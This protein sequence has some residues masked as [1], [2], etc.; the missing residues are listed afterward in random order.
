VST[1]LVGGL[2]MTHGDDDGVVLP[3]RLAPQQVVILPIYKDAE[4]RTA[5][6]GACDALKRELTDARY[7]DEPLRVQIDD[8]DLRGGEKNW[9]HVKRG[10]PI[11]VEIGPRDLDAGVVSVAR[12]DQ[13]PRERQSL[14]R[15]RFAAEA[16]AELGRIQD[17][18]LERARAF[19]DDHTERVGDL[20]ALEEYFQDE[21]RSGF[22]VAPMAAEAEEDPG[23][24]ELLKRLRITPRC[25]IGAAGEN[26]AASSADRTC[27]FT[28]ARGAAEVVFARAY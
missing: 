22:A 13:P 6:L 7:A 1:R 27:A 20:G 14:P 19:R 15:E 18:L 17:G 25:I 11:R 5:V 9:H 28:G 26:G 24:Q 23:F 12:R 16:P 4:Q 3:P 2:I 10:V 8:R 21:E